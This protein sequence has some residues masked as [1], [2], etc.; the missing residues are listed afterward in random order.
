MTEPNL[1]AYSETEQ[2]YL[3]FIFMHKQM[4]S[5]KEKLHLIEIN[6]RNYAIYLMINLLSIIYLIDL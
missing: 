6:L 4:D 5:I 1:I 3:E 2:L